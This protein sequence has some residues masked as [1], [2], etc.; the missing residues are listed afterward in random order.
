MFIECQTQRSSDNN[1]ELG[2][3]SHSSTSATNDYCVQQQISYYQP[4]QY[5]ER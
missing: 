1:T 5:N 4:A 2:W 3:S